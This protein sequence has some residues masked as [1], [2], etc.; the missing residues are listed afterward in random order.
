MQ[1][2]VQSIKTL[3]SNIVLNIKTIWDFIFKSEKHFYL[4]IPLGYIQQI[5][6][7]LKAS[8]YYRTYIDTLRAFMFNCY[9]VKF[10]YN[11]R[12]AERIYGFEN[13]FLESFN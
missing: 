3:T 1:Q 8:K 11:I 7:T 6:L 2:L 9:N 13:N 5:I 12:L 10:S 4:H